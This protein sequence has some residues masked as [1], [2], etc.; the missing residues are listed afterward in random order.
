M[1]DIEDVA[2]D[3]SI[4]PSQ[5]NETGEDAEKRRLTR[6]VRSAHEREARADREVD[7]AKDHAIVQDD[8][9][10]VEGCA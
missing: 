3:L 4:A 1:A 6:S 10:I 2:R 8:R 5:R 7:R 9:G